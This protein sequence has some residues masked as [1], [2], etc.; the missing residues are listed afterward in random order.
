MRLELAKS[1]AIRQRQTAKQKRSPPDPE[2][3][4]EHRV[5]DGIGAPCGAWPTVEEL[6]I[7]CCCPF[8]NGSAATSLLGSR[9]N[10][11]LCLNTLDA[12]QWLPH[13]QGQD[14]ANCALSRG[15]TLF[16]AVFL[17]FFSQ[18]SHHHLSAQHATTNSVDTR[19]TEQITGQSRK[20]IPFT[21]VRGCPIAPGSHHPLGAN[22]R[23]LPQTV[24]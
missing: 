21:A 23:K 16:A 15:D 10:H 12:R 6:G 7:A 20:T 19:D 13:A 8:K 17:A 11:T 5:R 9:L 2:A 22:R 18:R 4:C 24:I 1:A 3:P 14:V